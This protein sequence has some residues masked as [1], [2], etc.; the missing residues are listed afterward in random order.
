MKVA[1][2]HRSLKNFNSRVE[3]LICHSGQHY[4]AKMS[5]IFFEDLELPEPDEAAC[6]RHYAAHGAAMLAPEEVVDLVVPAGFEQHGQIKAG[7]NAASV[8]KWRQELSAREVATMESVGGDWLRTFVTRSPAAGHR[9]SPRPGSGS[10]TGGTCA[11]SP[12]G[13]L[14]ATR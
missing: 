12:G 7:V 5:R 14:A 4:D 13:E 11:T 8:A 10:G 9:R 1:P 3:H 6:R 2:L